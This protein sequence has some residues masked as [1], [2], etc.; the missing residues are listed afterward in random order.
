[1]RI[2]SPSWTTTPWKS[3]KTNSCG[4]PP[5]RA[6]NESAPDHSL[7]PSTKPP[8]GPISSSDT[9]DEGDLPPY[10]LRLDPRVAAKITR[11]GVQNADFVPL[12]ATM[13][14]ELERNPKAY[15]L[16]TG[17][18]AEA[19]AY[20]IEYRGPTWRAIFIVD[21]EFSE[22]IVLSFGPHDPAYAEAE[23]RI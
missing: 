18:L 9:H 22:F 1:L 17:K 2:Y 7:T 11:Y 15:P 13:L 20:H 21:D 4:E 6:V 12:I 19:R 8:A 14:D 10:D 23:R 16:K 3:T 5:L